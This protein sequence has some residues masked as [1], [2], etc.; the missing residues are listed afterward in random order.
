[1]N[2]KML[3]PT[4]RAIKPSTTTTNSPRRIEVRSADQIAE[5]A[6]ELPDRVA[7]APKARTVP[8]HD[9]AI[10]PNTACAVSSMIS[11]S[12]APRS[13]IASAKP[14]RIANSTLQYVARASAPTRCRDD[15]EDEIDDFCALPARHS[16]RPRPHRLGGKPVAD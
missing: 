4:N 10:T 12:R 13:P 5:R 8:L 2:L 7:M 14:N 3:N 6:A 11:R 16:W 1:M 9:D 15:V